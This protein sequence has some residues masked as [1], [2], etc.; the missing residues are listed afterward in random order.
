VSKKLQ[1]KQARRLAA[2]Q[3][4][5]AQKAAQRRGNLITIGIAL[6]VVIV[7]VALV[8]RDRPGAEGPIGVAESR[9]GCSDIE[10]FDEQGRDHVDAGTTVE[11][12]TTPPTS[13]PHWPPDQVAGPGFYTSPIEAERLVHNMEHGQLV[14]WYDPAA[15]AEVRD[16]IEAFVEENLDAILAAPYDQVPEG[17]FTITAW[18]ASM[19]C[20]QFSEAALADFRERFQG[21]GPEP[22]GVPQFSG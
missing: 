10:T 12:E 15:P 4:K 20:E 14:I 16:D 11:Y 19:S 13:G 9:A 6:V 8:L 7:V 17:T 5:A 3:R 2:E 18:T 21:R 1:E 22:V